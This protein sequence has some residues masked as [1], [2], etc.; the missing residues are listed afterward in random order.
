[1]LELRNLGKS[2]PH[3]DGRVHALSGVTLSAA[4]GEFVAIQGPSGCGKST[5]LLLAGGL[6]EPEEGQVVVE[7][8]DLYALSAEARARFRAA[9]IGFVFQRFHLIPYL[10]VEENILSVGLA[11]AIPDAR[12]RLSEAIAHFGLTERRHHI[13]AELSTGER[14][15]TALARALLNKPKL[16]LADEPTGNLD[17]DNAAIVLGHLADV[18][19]GG[20]TVLLVTHDRAAAGKA[21][22]IVY[23]REGKLDGSAMA[24]STP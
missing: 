17:A 10:T 5:L 15:R 1:V 9:N 22:R 4:A 11:S 6:L 14:Q 21:Q 13:P 2:Y 7:G 24:N 12:E 23:L 20:S 16:V 8:Q 19:R 18:A 3:P